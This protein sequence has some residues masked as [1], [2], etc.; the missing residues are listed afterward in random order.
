MNPAE[1]ATALLI[2]RTLQDSPAFRKI[3]D[4]LYVIKQSQTTIRQNRAMIGT[5]E[6]ALER[7]S[8]SAAA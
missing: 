7:L 4:S 2:E 5:A 1:V 8:R 3:D 6:E